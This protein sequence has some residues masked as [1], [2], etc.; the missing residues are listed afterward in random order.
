MLEKVAAEHV[1]LTGKGSGLLVAA[2]GGAAIIPAVE[3]RVADNIDIHHAIFIPVICYLYSGEPAGDSRGVDARLQGG[4]GLV[5]GTG[6]GCIGCLR[7][8]D[9]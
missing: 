3:V 9:P 2:I 7:V 5:G 4:D 1:S 6:A 8:A